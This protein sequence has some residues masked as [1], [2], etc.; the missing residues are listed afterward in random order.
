MKKIENN[1]NESENKK[2]FEEIENAVKIS[3][4]FK[5]NIIVPQQ[6]D[7]TGEKWGIRIGNKLACEEIFTSKEN[8]EIFISGIPFKILFALICAVAEMIYEKNNK[9]DKEL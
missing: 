3:N 6:L 7:E 8:A 2:A 9:K 1:T 4:E 5:K